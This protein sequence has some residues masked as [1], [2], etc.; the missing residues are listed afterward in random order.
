MY[1]GWFRLCLSADGS[2]ATAGEWG[3]PAPGHLPFWFKPVAPLACL[4]SRRLSA[5]HLSWPCHPPWPP[6]AVALAVVGSSRKRPGHPDRVRFRCPKSFAPSDYSGS[7]VLVGYQWSHTGSCPGCR[8]VITATFA[9]SC[10]TPSFSGN[11]YL[12]QCAVNTSRP[13]SNRFSLLELRV[14]R[15]GTKPLRGGKDEGSARRRLYRTTDEAKSR[16]GGA[17]T[18]GWTSHV[19]SPMSIGLLTGT[20]AV[21]VE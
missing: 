18:M 11:G 17:S 14:S 9:A 15:T 10:R 12:T 16:S 8:P 5:D 20:R 1:H 4:K 3:A 6:T 19:T 2:T 13:R 7:H 21:W